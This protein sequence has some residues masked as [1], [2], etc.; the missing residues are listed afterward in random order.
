MDEALGMKGYKRNIHTVVPSLFSALSI[1]ENSD[2]VVTLPE[3]V[4]RTNGRRFDIVRRPLPIEGGDFQLQAVRHARN[5]NSP[6]H[7][8]L[9]E[10]LRRIVSS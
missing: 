4:A 9:L 2:L 10:N 6:L 8:W 5:A 3:R 1:I 7:F